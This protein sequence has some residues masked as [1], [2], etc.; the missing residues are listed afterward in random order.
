MVNRRSNVVC[1]LSLPLTLAYMAVILLISSTPGVIPDDAALPYR[2]FVWLP[3]DLQNFLHVPV[4]GGLAFLWCGVL[5]GRVSP[6]ACM[7]GSFLLATG[8]GF[9]DEWYQSFIPGRFASL[10]DILLNAVGAA[11]GVGV[12][13]QMLNSRKARRAP[14]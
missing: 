14:G 11:V 9:I 1:R 3:S 13:F 12:Y 7:A 4:Y 5:H 6:L 2:V 8:F 10:G